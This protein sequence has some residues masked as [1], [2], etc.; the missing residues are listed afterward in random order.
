MLQETKKKRT[1]ARRFG[2]GCW[3]VAKKELIRCLMNQNWKGGRLPI[4]IRKI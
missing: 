1:F 3:R 4:K 2:G